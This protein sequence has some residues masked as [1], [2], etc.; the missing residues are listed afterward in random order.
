[1]K[2]CSGKTERQLL[3]HS[4]C[5][6]LLSCGKVGKGRDRPAPIIV[7]RSRVS[8]QVNG[9]RSQTRDWPVCSLVTICVSWLQCQVSHSDQSF[10]E[11][12]NISLL[13]G[14]PT[15]DV[16][17]GRQVMFLS[18]PPPD[19]GPITSTLTGTGRREESGYQWVT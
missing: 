5:C 3:D 10:T 11:Q 12:L 7:L 16:R 14:L 13:S 15:P 17:L 2:L 18:Q 4:C 6:C 1:M 9:D 8:S 19:P